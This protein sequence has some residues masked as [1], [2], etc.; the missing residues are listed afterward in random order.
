MRDDFQKIESILAI[1]IRIKCIHR[2]EDLFALEK[3]VK[4]E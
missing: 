1:H 4:R 2:A 3:H